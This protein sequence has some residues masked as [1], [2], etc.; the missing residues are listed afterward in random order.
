M[1]PVAPTGSATGLVISRVHNINRALS[2][3]MYVTEHEKTRLVY[4]KYTY[5]QYYDM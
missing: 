4:T 3:N 2:T 1:P 5:S